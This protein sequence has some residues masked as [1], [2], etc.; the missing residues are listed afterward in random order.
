MHQETILQYLLKMDI[1]YNPTI[2]LLGIYLTEMNMYVHLKAYTRTFRAALFI[3]T[4]PRKLI[5]SPSI[6][7][8]NKPTGIWL[9]IVVT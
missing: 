3:I 2:Q 8:I 1:P 9:C 4:K 6:E 7:R 5:S